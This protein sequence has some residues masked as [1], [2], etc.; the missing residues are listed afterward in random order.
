MINNFADSRV[1]S[2]KLTPVYIWNSQQLVPHYKVN[3]ASCR[4]ISVGHNK[5]Y[6]RK[7]TNIHALLPACVLYNILHF[8]KLIYLRLLHL[9]NLKPRSLFS[10]TT[11]YHVNLIFFSYNNSITNHL[12][13]TVIFNSTAPQHRN[14]HCEQTYI[15]K[16]KKGERSNAKKI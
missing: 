9:V 1:I 10:Y 7:V 2:N 11:L 16:K 13:Y 3:I 4:Y 5:I 6:M 12:L 15:H 8:H 14:I